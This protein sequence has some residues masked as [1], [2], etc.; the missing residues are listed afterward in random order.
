MTPNGTFI[1]NGT[2]RVIVSR[3]TAARAFLDHDKGRRTL[4]SALRLPDHPYRGSWL[5]FEFDA[6]TVFAA[7]T[8]A[9]S[10]R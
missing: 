9:A 1:V 5:D 10:C 7:S 2:E 3:C 6:R 8:V 4:G